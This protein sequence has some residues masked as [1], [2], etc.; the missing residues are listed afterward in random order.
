MGPKTKVEREAR[1]LSL[2]DADVR[3]L[4]AEIEQKLDRNYGSM[5]WVDVNQ[6]N[7]AIIDYVMELYRSKG[8]KVFWNV[9]GQRDEG[10]NRL[11]IT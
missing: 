6:C 4:I 11:E 10:L 1:F 3:E 2:E 8:F 5:V 9:G 7:R